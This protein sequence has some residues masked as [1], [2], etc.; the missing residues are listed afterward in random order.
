MSNPN[1][2]QLVSRLRGSAA[3]QRSIGLTAGADL[4]DQAA[5]TIDDLRAT[6][7]VAVAMDRHP[8]GTQR[9]ARVITTKQEALALRAGA[10]VVNGPGTAFQIKPSETAEAG[11][12]DHATAAWLLPL[13][14]IHEGQPT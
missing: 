4:L 14:V 1:L 13:T 6:T 7:A 11:Y 8:A 2:D 12:I 5:S 9:T 3:L 10:V